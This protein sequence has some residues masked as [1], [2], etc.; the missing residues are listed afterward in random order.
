MQGFGY[1]AVGFLLVGEQQSRGSIK[2]TCRL[3]HSEGRV[4]MDILC[5]SLFGKL[6]VQL[7]E[8]VVTN[9][10]G[11][12]QDLFCYLLLYR[13][14]PHP[15]EKLASLLWGDN[16]TAQAKG[17][18][19]KALW[20]FQTALDSQTQSVS[21]GL[22]L[23]EPG[24]VQINPRSDFWLDVA[25]FEQTFT[26]VSDV[27]GQELGFQQVLTLL[28]AVGLY[29]GDLLEGCYQEWCLYERERF[30]HMYL[31]MLDKLMGYCEA[32][33]E[34]GAGLAC[35]ALILRYD[36]AQERTHWRMMRLHHLSGDRTAALRQ[37][38]RCSA[39]LDEELGVKPAKR[40]VALYEQIR[41]DQIYDLTPASTDE[42]ITISKSPVSPLTEV[43]K[44]LK[45]HQT[46][47]ADLRRQI[48]RDIQ[49]VELALNGQH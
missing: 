41:S 37:Y 26:L 6:H 48:Q 49:A 32:R 42:T 1:L 21:N 46:V 31:V 16:L 43:L 34:Y 45:Q 13:H 38:E 27:P 8:Q 28:N 7:G 30:Q 39:A 5:V 9:F 17:Y 19:R 29:Q 40:T 15:R 12:V 10:A 24:W 36:K 44:R 35:G 3:E 18:L 47:L 23:V 25:I 14:H 4:S 33:R 20:Q 22:L 2:L 11:K